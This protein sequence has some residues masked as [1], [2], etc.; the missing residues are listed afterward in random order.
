M[1]APTDQRDCLTVDFSAHEATGTVRGEA[2]VRVRPPKRPAW[3]ALRL[4]RYLAQ[5]TLLRC[6][7]LGPD[8]SPLGPEHDAAAVPCGDDPRSLDLQV[9]LGPGAVS[10][11]YRLEWQLDPADHPTIGVEG[12]ELRL[13]RAHLLGRGPDGA[14]QVREQRLI[15]V[16]WVKRDA[17]LGFRA[18]SARTSGPLREALKAMVRAE[19]KNLPKC[20]ECRTRYELDRLLALDRVWE[21]S[22]EPELEEIRRLVVER[23]R[24]GI[25]GRDVILRWHQSH[26]HEDLG[27]QL[28]AARERH[29]ARLDSHAP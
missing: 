18:R 10:R 25:P 29:R 7:D 16:E 26:H 9:E 20:P 28:A 24:A 14:E 4:R 5:L 23:E 11:E 1:T 13:Y 19:E 22:T 3:T 6:R 2:L 17:L 15:T 8:G 21:C 27:R 12:R